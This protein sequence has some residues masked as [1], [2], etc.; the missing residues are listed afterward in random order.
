MSLSTVPFLYLPPSG[1]LQEFLFVGI[2]V[3]VLDDLINAFLTA[4]FLFSF[5]NNKLNATPVSPPPPLP[6]TSPASNG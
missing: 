3:V 5:N 2:I 1:F 4:A 6:R